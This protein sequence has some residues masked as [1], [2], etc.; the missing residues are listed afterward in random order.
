[1]LVFSLLKQNTKTIK[2]LQLEFKLDMSNTYRKERNGF[3]STL[4]QAL[5]AVRVGDL[6]EI[7]ADQ[8][9]ITKG[10]KN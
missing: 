2:T 6:Q 3:L 8:R 5:D 7:H 9:S 1:L 10:I 4:Q